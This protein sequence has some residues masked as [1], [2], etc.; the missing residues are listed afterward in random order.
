MRLTPVKRTPTLDPPTKLRRT[1]R[2]LTMESALATRSHRRPYRSCVSAE[3]LPATARSAPT[4]HASPMLP[5]SF[6][7]P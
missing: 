4:L 5:V 3:E 2:T 6:I 1:R 7:A